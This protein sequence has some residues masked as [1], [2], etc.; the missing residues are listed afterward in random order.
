MWYGLTL[1]D[2]ALWYAIIT[3][4]LLLFYRCARCHFRNHRAF[5][6]YIGA[7]AAK[8]LI[9]AAT[10]HFGSPVAYFYA[11]Y[12]LVGLISLAMLPAAVEVAQQVFAPYNTIPV[13]HVV[14]LI[15]AAAL[16]AVLS[17]V[18]AELMGFQT[19]GTFWARLILMERY[20]QTFVGIGLI[21][22]ALI[23]HELGL[24]WDVQTR[25]VCAGFIFA[26]LIQSVNSAFG[27][28]GELAK[29]TRPI[30]MLAFLIAQMVWLAGF[31]KAAEPNIEANEDVVN[32]MRSKLESLKQ[33][34]GVCT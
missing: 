32:T 19:Q 7:A 14:R 17:M 9:L 21:A 29:W 25:N 4:D 20:L 33:A 6:I 13:R 30:G 31:M 2:S 34:G 28:H 26:M 12:I 1:L 18:I 11:Y 5:T 23:A 8:S 10:H 24:P 15:G 3:A 22:V 16:F 27:L